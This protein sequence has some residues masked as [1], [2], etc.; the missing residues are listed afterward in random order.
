MRAAS[1]RPFRASEAADVAA[2]MYEPPYEIYNG[3]P[4][5]QQNYLSVDADGY[6]Y[7]A[8]VDTDSEDVI[9]FCCF[10]PEARVKGQ[11]Q[12]QGTI[13]IGGGV[14]PDLL[15][16]GIATDLLPLVM[17]FARDQFAPQRFRTVVASFNERS[18]RLCVSAGFEIVRRFE[19]P[20]REF[21]ELLRQA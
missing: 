9:G 19:D 13:D 8:V 12:R 10:G 18:T 4:E 1:I 6:G 11:E 3:D 17:D 16:E 2:W 21:K 7:Y 14:R 20:T 15:S 5:S